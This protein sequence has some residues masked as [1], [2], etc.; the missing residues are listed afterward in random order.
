MNNIKKFIE[1]EIQSAK[2]ETVEEAVRVIEQ[3]GAPFEWEEQ[4]WSECVDKVILHITSH[5]KNNK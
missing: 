3:M 1:K 4:S 5:Y 2:Q